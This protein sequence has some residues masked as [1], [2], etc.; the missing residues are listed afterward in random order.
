MCLQN[1]GP[2]GGFSM[3]VCAAVGALPT[4]SGE[5]LVFTNL[6]SPHALLALELASLR[7]VCERCV[8]RHVPDDQPRSSTGAESRASNG[9]GAALEQQHVFEKRMQPVDAEKTVFFACGVW[10][11][12]GVV[13]RVCWGGNI[14]IRGVLG[15]GQRCRVVVRL[16]LWLV[17]SEGNSASVHACAM[18]PCAA[19]SGKKG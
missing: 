11:R 12:G 4:C 18:H 17:G 2:W 19:Q 6:I 13:I 7:H 8:L 1:M 14:V 10:G 3:R 15:E 5:L 9:I 16:C